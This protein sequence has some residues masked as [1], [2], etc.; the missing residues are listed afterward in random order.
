M[1]IDRSEFV[2]SAQRTGGVPQPPACISPVLHSKKFTISSRT[3]ALLYNARCF[4]SLS[5][6]NPLRS[7]RSSAIAAGDS[8]APRR[9][10]AIAATTNFPSRSTIPALSQ[11]VV[12]PSHPIRRRELLDRKGPSTS[13]DTREHT[14]GNRLFRDHLGLSG[15]RFPRHWCSRWGQS[16]SRRGQDVSTRT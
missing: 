9:R 15:A 12:A 5:P 10:G 2:R 4:A 3:R 8:H 7:V 14:S 6:T 13:T 16:R 1:L 11:P